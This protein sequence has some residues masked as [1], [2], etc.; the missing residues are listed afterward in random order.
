MMMRFI[1]VFVSISDVAIEKFQNNNHR[2]AYKFKEGLVLPNNNG[3]APGLFLK[4]V[5]NQFSYYLDLQQS[6]N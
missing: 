5:I 1:K 2:Q 3:T 4:R 6:L